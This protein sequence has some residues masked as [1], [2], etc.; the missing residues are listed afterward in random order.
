MCGS[1][2]ILFTMG[3]YYSQIFNTTAGSKNTKNST[4]ANSSSTAYPT[5][6][7]GDSSNRTVSGRLQHTTQDRSLQR[8]ISLAANTGPQDRTAQR[9]VS[10]ASPD[11]TAVEVQ[12][13]RSYYLPCF[14]AAFPNMNIARNL[15]PRTKFALVGKQPHKSV[16]TVINIVALETLTLM[17]LHCCWFRLECVHFW[18]PIS[19]VL[20]SMGSRE[21]YECTFAVKK[22]GIQ[23]RGAC[24]C[25]LDNKKIAL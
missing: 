5:Y 17:C 16:N 11:L 19:M 15:S 22:Y 8:S 23:C 25:G 2:R 24:V 3:P 21:F 13:W 20:P 12:N 7:T 10:L 18:L 1:T 4:T 9:S 6:L 14:S